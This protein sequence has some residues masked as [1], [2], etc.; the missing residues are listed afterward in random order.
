M[1]HVLIDMTILAGGSD[2]FI[3][4]RQAFRDDPRTGAHKKTCMNENA[5]ELMRDAI[6]DDPHIR[7]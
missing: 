7:M 5:I 4:A 2:V 3:S 6:A 1:E